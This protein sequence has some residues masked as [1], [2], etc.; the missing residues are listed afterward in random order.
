MAL[1]TDNIELWQCYAWEDASSNFNQWQDKCAQIAHQLEQ[2]KPRDL[3]FP[4]FKL[5]RLLQMRFP[6]PILSDNT[7]D[8]KVLFITHHGNIVLNITQEEFEQYRAGRSFRI[9]LKGNG[10]INQ[11]HQN[12][13]KAK[14]NNAFCRF[15]KNGYLEIGQHNENAAKMLGFFPYSGQQIFYSNVKIIFE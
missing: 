5:D 1:G 6:R 3:G 13:A 4:S 9:D 14:S 15:N 10:Y 12:I 11:I 8:C 7:I 2:Q